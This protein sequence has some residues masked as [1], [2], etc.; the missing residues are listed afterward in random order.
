MRR[1]PSWPMR[2]G[3]ARVSVGLRRQRG[4]R[5]CRNW[6][7]AASRPDVVTDQT[8]A[9]DPLNGYLPTAG[10]SIAG[11]R[12]APRASRSSSGD[13][14]RGVAVGGRHVAA[15]LGLHAQ[16][17]AASST[18]AT[19]SARWRRTTASPNAFDIPGF[20]P[21]YIR[22]L[23]CEGIGPFRWVALSGDPADIHRDRRAGSRN[24]SRT[25]RT[26]TAGSTWRAS[27]SRSRGCRRGS[28]GS[29]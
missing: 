11:S 4:R 14:R 18:T 19:T 26:C 22:P 24:W 13:R 25:T 21:A 5:C 3:P 9:H 28:A 1:W 23:F 2:S 29:G 7:R 16:A 12:R 20:V 27:G 8:S 15:M 10:P 6:W 17:R